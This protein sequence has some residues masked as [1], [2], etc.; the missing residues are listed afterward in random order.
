MLENAKIAMLL[1]LAGGALAVFNIWAWAD[2]LNETP[3]W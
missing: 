2:K 1:L 3:I